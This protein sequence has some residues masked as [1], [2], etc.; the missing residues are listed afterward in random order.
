V[1]LMLLV[2]TTHDLSLT[3]HFRRSGWQWPL[4]ESDVV[5]VWQR[6]DCVA[7]LPGTLVAQLVRHYVGGALLQ[8]QVTRYCTPTAGPPRLPAPVAPSRRRLLHADRRGQS[9]R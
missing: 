6:N 8:T 5:R 4:G 7:E 1:S 9:R 3:V 2:M